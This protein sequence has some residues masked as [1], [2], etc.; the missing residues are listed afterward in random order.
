MAWRAIASVWIA[1]VL[2]TGKALGISSRV[3]SVDVTSKFRLALIP[4]W[5]SWQNVN[6]LPIGV[7]TQN[8]VIQTSHAVLN[9]PIDRVV[10]L[11]G[12][13]RVGLRLFRRPPIG[14]VLQFIKEKAEALLLS[15]GERIPECLGFLG[16]EHWSHIQKGPASNWHRAFVY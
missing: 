4:L 12:L 8:P 15:R 5:M 1:I 2:V 11:S 10:F 6:R 9:R 13:W 14:K 7:L 3:N 16:S